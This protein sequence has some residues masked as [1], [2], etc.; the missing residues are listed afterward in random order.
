MSNN[1]IYIQSC[2]IIFCWFK[3]IKAFQD[4][5]GWAV[6]KRIEMGMDIFKVLSLWAGQQA[7]YAVILEKEVVEKKQGKKS[8]NFIVG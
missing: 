4:I 6:A 1:M 5:S 7:Y 8:S 3:A 2:S